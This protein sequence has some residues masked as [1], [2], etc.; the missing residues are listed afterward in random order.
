MI[1]NIFSGL[2]TKNKIDPV[3]T[4]RTVSHRI[5]GM[6]AFSHSLLLRTS[7]NLESKI[8]EKKIGTRNAV[9]NFVMIERPKANAESSSHLCAPNLCHSASAKNDSRA[10]VMDGRPIMI[11]TLSLR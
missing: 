8:P 9:N 11:D 1:W 7:I 4:D 2:T 6:L 3:T 10:R 5:D